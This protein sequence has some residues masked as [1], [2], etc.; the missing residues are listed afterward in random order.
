MPAPSRPSRFFPLGA[1]LASASGR[2]MGGGDGLVRRSTGPRGS[3]LGLALAS[4]LVLAA[5]CSPVV[6]PARFAS[7]R[8]RVTDVSLRGPFDGQVVDEGTA[9]PIQGATVVGVWSYDEGDGL[10]GPSGSQVVEVKTDQAGR[11][12]IPAAPE[13][14]RA[15]H[16]RASLGAPLRLVSFELIVYK[17]GYVGYRSDRHLDGSPRGDF[18]LRHNRVELRK[19]RDTDSHAEHLVFLAAP[20]AV[21]RLSSWERE[22]ANL[23]LYRA[24]GGDLAGAAAAEPTPAASL[25]LLDASALL[26]PEDVRRRTGYT[27]AFEV[28]ELGDLAHT[29]FYHGVHLQAVDRDEVWDVAYRV[30]KDPPG[31]LQPVVETFEATLPG[32]SVTGEVTSESWVYDGEDVRAVAFLDRERNVGVLLTCGAMQCIDVETAIILAS[33]LHENIDSLTLV[34]APSTPATPT[35]APTG[36]PTMSSRPPREPDAGAS[37][38]AGSEAADPTDPEEGTP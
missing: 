22:S 34:D 16:R 28:K 20:A 3:P 26:R 10:V 32:V 12:R 11:Y 2:W 5:A 35:A 19:W 38:G 15:A 8:D 17:R 14:E 37:D 1:A 33:L 18:T 31:G 24:L 4:L 21:T 7:A 29:H 30:W 23:D 13:H 6:R 9:E 27:D 25:Q 36:R